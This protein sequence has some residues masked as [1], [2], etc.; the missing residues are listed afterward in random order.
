VKPWKAR[1]AWVS[2]VAAATVGV[3]VT[4]AGPAAAFN[5]SFNVLTTDECG[6]AGFVD[7]GEG[8]P[9]GGN[10]DD[11][12]VVNDWCGDHHGVMAYAWITHPNQATQYLG[13]KYDG[14]GGTGD[15]VYWDP[16][17]SNNVKTGDLVGLKVCLVDGASDQTPFNCK[18]ASYTSQDG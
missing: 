7:Y 6:I 5:D 10:N 4:T 8:A 18:S 2:V 3:L 9:G 17:P 14:N 13:D 16:F 1:V 15:P 11:Y 12:I